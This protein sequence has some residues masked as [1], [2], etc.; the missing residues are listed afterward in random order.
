MT[1][2]VGSP[3][4]D[5]TLPRDGNLTLSLSQLKGKNI[6]LYFYPKDDTPGCTLE[7]CGFR[8]SYKEFQKLDTE[9]IGV[10]K[11][12]VE[13]HDKFKDKFNLP[14]PLVSDKSD[15]L[16]EAFEVWKE[17]SMYGKKYM[18]IERSTFLIDAQGVLREIWRGVKVPGHIEDVLH[19]VK[20]L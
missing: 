17:K 3:A 6:V 9:I 7:S 8:D 13:S 15:K 1:V 2:K 16:C 19:A 5:F 12:S 10:S 11:D 20:K 18:G 14:F 4:P